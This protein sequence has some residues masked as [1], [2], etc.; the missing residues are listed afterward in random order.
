MSFLFGTDGVRGVVGEKITEKFVYELSKSIAVFLNKQKNGSNVLLC[1]DTRLSAKMIEQNVSKGF[2]EFGINVVCGG[3]VPTPAVHYLTKENN[4]DLGVMITASHNPAEFN[5]IKIITKDGLKFSSHQEEEVTKIYENVSSFSFSGSCGNVYY[6]DDLKFKWTDWL[7]SVVDDDFSGIKIA[8][9]CANGANYLLAPHIFKKLG[10]QVVSIND[11][12]K[13]KL[14]NFNCGSTHLE[15]I[16]A[17]TKQ[18]GCDLG[19]AFDGDADRVNAVLKTGKPI[20]GEELLFLC[21]MFLKKQNGLKGNKI[22]TPYVSNCGIDKSLSKFKID[23]IRC[24]VGGKSIQQNMLDKNISFGAEDNG[25]IVWG[26]YN[27]CSDGLLTALFLTKLYKN[28]KFKDILK[29]LKLFK[30]EKI[31]VPITEEQTQNYKTGKIDFEIENLKKSLKQNERIIV[32]LSGTEPIM[33]IVVEGE[34]EKRLKTFCKEAEKL[35]ESLWH[36]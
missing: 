31:T 1:H 19:F 32:R 29:D 21:C 18:N 4:F 36:F 5:G 27:K 9:D 15:Q 2:C 34:N 12:N 33:R 22:I 23:V 20:L 7:L 30:Q 24:D 13:G 35:V 6:D 3:I 16:S 28:Q 25:H 11:E 8:L 10:A 26:D 17:I 14:I